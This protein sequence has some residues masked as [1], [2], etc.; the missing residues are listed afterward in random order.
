[1]S[2][3][4]AIAVLG[5]LGAVFGLV[6]AVASKVFAVE[7]DERLEP[8]IEALPGANCG[9]CGYSGCAAYAQAVLEGKAKIG[10]CASGG[11]ASAQAMAKIMGIEA[12]KVERRV[13]MVMC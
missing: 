9:G 13:A 5:V 3:V 12:A 10:L 1:M 7:T 8:M 2:L 11:D 4:Y 6:L